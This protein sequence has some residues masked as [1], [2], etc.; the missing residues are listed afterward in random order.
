MAILFK[1]C[2]ERDG[3]TF[4]QKEGKK[5]G[6]NSALKRKKNNFKAMVAE[7]KDVMDCISSTYLFPIHR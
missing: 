7:K 1:E 6:I 4:T 3:K 2:E 5:T